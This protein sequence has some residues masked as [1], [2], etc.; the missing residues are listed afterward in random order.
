M[1]APIDDQ[2][3]RPRTDRRRFNSEAATNLTRNRTVLFPTPMD[4]LV[5]E[6]VLGVF[7]YFDYSTLVAARL[8]C[9]RFYD[10]SKTREIWS[11]LYREL[12]N[13]TDYRLTGEA[14][15]HTAQELEDW[16]SRRHKAMI[17]LAEL[18]SES[19]NRTP[20]YNTVEFQLPENV[21]LLQNKFIASLLP[22]GRFL[23]LSTIDG[24]LLFFD[25]ETPPSE[26]NPTF[27]LRSMEESW[28]RNCHFMV[29]TWVDFSRPHYTCY[30]SR[31]WFRNLISVT[32][33]VRIEVIE[34]GMEVTIRSRT[35]QGNMKHDFEM[36]KYTAVPSFAISR[37]YILS[38]NHIYAPGASTRIS[39]FHVMDYTRP[40][41]EG[42][43]LDAERDRWQRVD[44]PGGD[45]KFMDRENVFI[46]QD[47]NDIY[48]FE[49]ENLEGKADD[50]YFK[51]VQ[52][53]HVSLN[54]PSGDHAFLFN[55]PVSWRSTSYIFLEPKFSLALLF[56]DQSYSPVVVNADLTKEEMRHLMGPKPLSLS[57]E[58]EQFTGT[59]WSISYQ[60]HRKNGISRETFDLT[61]HEWDYASSKPKISRARLPA[62]PQGSNAVRDVLAF[63]EEIGRLVLIC[64]DEDYR[65]PTILRYIYLL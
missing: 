31:T 11:G 56:E 26:E 49:I 16:V 46:V 18:A 63:G 25:L 28:M 55:C 43:Y 5:D 58:R 9:K 23:P 51:I 54:R 50:Q 45:I 19:S 40:L 48:V 8:T 44:L 47:S 20:A 38:A 59:N 14:T 1:T 15:A 62:I 29:S 22:G 3:S 24:D 33:I 21:E 35:V 10:I 60:V 30:S 64:G 6:L 39:G 61:R 42:C 13:E 12:K 27:L 34:D 7:R 57:W 41:E 53:H 4:C 52:L 32:F 65:S 2:L 36:S 37:R 17:G